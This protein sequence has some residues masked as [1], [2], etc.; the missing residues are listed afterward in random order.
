MVELEG[1]V[2]GAAQEDEAVEIDDGVA[3]I[4][5]GTAAPENDEGGD[6]ERAIDA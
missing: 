3:Q 6:K 4:F 5:A 1:K 2:S